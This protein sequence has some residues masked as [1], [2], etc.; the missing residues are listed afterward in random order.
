MPIT[1]VCPSCKTKLQV[2][3]EA[4]GKKGKCPKCQTAFMVPGGSPAA[5]AAAPPPKQ[6][7]KK[8]APPPEDDFSNLDDPDD[9]PVSKKGP[10]AKKGR[11]D[12]DDD[13]DDRP[14]SK[15]APPAKRGR[16]DDDD[17]DDRP[18][19]KK[20]APAKRGRDDDDD[21]DDRPVK[22]GAAKKGRDDDYDDEDEKPTKKGGKKGKKDDPTAN[23]P[24]PTEEESKAAFNMYLF[25]LLGNMLC[26]LGSILFLVTWFGK[27]KENPLI[28]WHGKQI[29]NTGITGTIIGIL[30]SILIG[31]G[32][33]AGGAMASGGDSGSAAGGGILAIIFWVLGFGFLFVWG[34]SASIFTLIGMFKAKSGVYYKF[35][36][37]LRLLK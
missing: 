19:S 3:D 7:V 12:Y 2:K 22:K 5:P 10:P 15:K 30:A 9:R 25:M 23:L 35:P 8:P 21:E 28:D 29:I 20:G 1:V 4:A 31:I 34:L 27:R 14:V 18:V 36:M 17:E 13:D 6:P 26:G 37:M 16:D 11:D 24:E 32:T 33:C